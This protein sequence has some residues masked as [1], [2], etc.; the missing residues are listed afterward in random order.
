VYTMR[1]VSKLW[2]GGIAITSMAF[3]NRTRW[4]APVS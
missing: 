4:P 2:I 1:M 3:T